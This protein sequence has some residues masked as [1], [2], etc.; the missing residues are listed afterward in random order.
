MSESRRCLQFLASLLAF[1][2]LALSAQAQV[3]TAQAAVRFGHFADL[4]EVALWQDAR[5]LFETP[6]ASVSDYTLL[7]AGERGF[8]L[9]PA[10]GEA[11]AAPAA[12]LEASLAAG[13]FYTLLALPGG[14]GVRLLLVEDAL[15]APSAG[16][17]KLRL[18]SASAAQPNLELQLELA[19]EDEAGAAAEAGPP[20]SLRLR[21]S[22]AD[23]RVTVTGPNGF[24]ETFQGSAT[25][26]ELAAGRYFVN[27]TRSGYQ[28]LARQVEVSDEAPAFVA[29][30]LE[31]L[32]SGAGEA[33]PNLLEAAT[34]SAS[35]YL[36]TAAGRYRASL[37]AGEDTLAEVSGL[38]LEPGVSYSLFVYDRAG[39]AVAV[40]LSLDALAFQQPTRESGDGAGE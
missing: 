19:E 38:D 29:L 9:R 16:A 20:G 8:E 34:G 22:P 23:S 28:P 36:E 5:P 4:A 31:P 37:R 30:R 35:S 1:A 27:A 3:P 21:L 40:A 33:A 13:S 6:F 26:R 39:G 11:E 25:L 2:G 17:A 12:R 15:P 10:G 32:D 14:E 18:V 7:A 24:L